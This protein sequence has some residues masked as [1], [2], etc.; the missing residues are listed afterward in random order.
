MWNAQMRF[1]QTKHDG[2]RD[3]T[4]IG[5]FNH[6]KEAKNPNTKQ[7]LREMMRASPVMIWGGCEAQKSLVDALSQPSVEGGTQSTMN[8]HLNGTPQ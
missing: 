4:W 7:H 6:G 5:M 8:P 1:E 3:G 2:G